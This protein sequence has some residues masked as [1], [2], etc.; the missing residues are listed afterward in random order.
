MTEALLTVAHLKQYFPGANKQ[1]IKAVDDVSFSVQPGET[2]GLVGESGSGKTTIGRAIIRLYHPTAGTVTFEGMPISGQMD[3]ATTKQLRTDM[4]MIFQDPMSSLNPRKKVADIIQLGLL[5]HHPEMS[6]ADRLEAVNVVLRRVGLDESFAVRYP[7]ELSGGQRQRV[8]I[9][10]ALI[11]KPKLIIADEAISALDVSVQAQVVNLLKEIQQD[12]GTA[13]LFIAHDLAMVRYISD[14]IGV[15]HLGHLV[16]I[17]TTEEIFEHPYHPYT[18]SL[19]AAIPTI[20]PRQRQLSSGVS[21]HAQA[22]QYE[23][24]SLHCIAGSHYVLANEAEFAKWQ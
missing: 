21:Y 9:A 3:A 22:Q 15:V 24:R 19:L 7:K 1:V 12:T 23:N 4:Q 10:R 11:L 2:F 8:G 14:H 17:G 5:T 20:N 6:K 18:K 16:E 13:M